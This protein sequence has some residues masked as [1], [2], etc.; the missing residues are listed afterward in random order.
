LFSGRHFDDRA[1]RNGP[2]AQ[3]EMKMALAQEYRIVLRD[4]NG[5]DIGERF[6]MGLKESKIAAKYLLSEDYA[7][8]IESTHA[9][10]QTAKAEV[11]NDSGEVVADYFLG[12]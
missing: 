12:Q 9:D 4:A 5:F 11:I 10:Q 3:G 6:A 2:Q 1:S 8:A 7:R